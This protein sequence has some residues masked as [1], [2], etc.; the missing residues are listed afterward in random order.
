VDIGARGAQ[1]HI[2]RDRVEME[3]RACVDHHRDLRPQHWRKGS[4][5]KPLAQ[6]RCELAGID[7][8][9]GIEA[10]ERIG[11]DRDATC[12]ENL[13]RRH[14]IRESAGRCR[15][16]AAHLEAAARADLDDAIAAAARR[17]A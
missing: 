6:R 15:G 16:E 5:G 10:S 2:G 4:H 11:D 1:P 8:G 17:H 3:R 9:C 12:G 7:Q 13:E 14:G